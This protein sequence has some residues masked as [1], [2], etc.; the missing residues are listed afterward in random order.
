MIPSDPNVNQITGYISV[1]TTTNALMFHAETT[2][3]LKNL[4]P[5]DGMFIPSGIAPGQGL[6]GTYSTTDPAL[7]TFAPDPPGKS[8]WYI[9]GKKENTGIWTPI[10]PPPKEAKDETPIVSVKEKKPFLHG[11]V[12]PGKVP[13]FLP[14]EGCSG[15][16][17]MTGNTIAHG[18]YFPPNDGEPSYFVP[19]AGNTIPNNTAGTFSPTC[20]IAQKSVSFA[21]TFMDRPPATLIINQ[22]MVTVWTNM[23]MKKTTS[24]ASN[25]MMKSHKDAQIYDPVDIMDGNFGFRTGGDGLAGLKDPNCP[26]F[27]E[28]IESLNKKDE[29]ITHS[30]QILIMDDKSNTKP[31]VVAAVKT[32]KEYFKTKTFISLKEY[33]EYIESN[34][35][36]KHTK[37]G[38]DR[39]EV[40]VSQATLKYVKKKKLKRLKININTDTKADA[41]GASGAGKGGAAA[42][43]ATSGV[44]ASYGGKDCKG[45]DTSAKAAAKAVNGSKADSTAHALNGGHAAAVSDAK[46]GSNAKANANVKEG[47]NANALSLAAKGGNSTS[48]ANAEHGANANAV[49]KNLNGT[50]TAARAN[51]TQEKKEDD[52]CGALGLPDTINVES[53]AEAHADGNGTGGSTASSTTNVKID[54]AGIVSKLMAQI[55][56]EDLGGEDEEERVI[57]INVNSASSAGAQAGRTFG[58]EGHVFLI[59]TLL[60]EIGRF[61]WVLCSA[62]INVH[63]FYE[64][65]NM[66]SISQT[67]CLFYFMLN[68]RM[69]R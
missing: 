26:A 19:D 63:A 54:M 51:A 36:I 60:K 4:E 57:S 52:P 34:Y 23:R 59:F 24:I 43:K 21:A 56:A 12:I 55:D 45:F 7:A 58:G 44:S 8:Y 3:A 68:L 13:I 37:V 64:Y 31:D 14:D 46:D 50:S 47:G 16:F 33:H 49:S 66:N 40:G 10:K 35:Q 32:V 48:N 38:E 6:V 61:L 2:T 39:I 29:S 42:G 9:Q 27:Q 53:H 17:H 11:V 18:T 67:D 1:N 28:Y 69:Y 20:L 65:L 15:E 5:G 22:P 62:Y 30:N 41:S 25:V